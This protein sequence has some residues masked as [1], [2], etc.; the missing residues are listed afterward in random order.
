MS[1][2]SR[3]LV[4]VTVWG[5]WPE[6]G[7][8]EVLSSSEEQ[9]GCTLLCDS[10]GPPPLSPVVAFFHFVP[11]PHR[12]FSSPHFSSDFFL[13]KT[14]DFPNQITIEVVYIDPGSKFLNTLVI[15]SSDYKHFRGKSVL[16]MCSFLCNIFVREECV[17]LLIGWKYCF[18]VILGMRICSVL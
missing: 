5:K 2:I 4:E 8:R 17:T 6:P 14:Q 10:A 18:H 1:A 11:L 13:G 3:L 7:D 9:A 15:A 16:L 12:H